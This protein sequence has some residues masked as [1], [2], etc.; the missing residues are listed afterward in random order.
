MDKFNFI[1]YTAKRYGIDFSVAETLVDMF[2]DTLQ[3]LLIAG[4]DVNID[5]IGQ[6]EA[7][8]LLPK[9]FNHRNNIILAKAK[10]QQ[11]VYF[12]PSSKLANRA[13]AS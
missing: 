7:M 2:S 10:Q 4:V 5:E 1:E 6:F 13:I 11:I 9:N 8:P 3:E 12:T